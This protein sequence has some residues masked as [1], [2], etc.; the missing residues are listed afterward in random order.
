[1]L[2]D[3]QHP[4]FF[5][6]R[7]RASGYY[8]R[9][10]CSRV[11]WSASRVG[12]IPFF[13]AGRRLYLGWTVHQFW[14]STSTVDS[15]VFCFCLSRVSSVCTCSIHVCLNTLKLVSWFSVFGFLFCLGWPGTNGEKQNLNQQ[16][17][18]FSG[19]TR[20]EYKR[21]KA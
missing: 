1:M 20:M 19:K 14:C 5:Q 16:T 13:R 10:C 17:L 12:T 7:S 11:L 18:G 8:H 9:P 6:R 4:Y 15:F 2:F 3:E 21:T